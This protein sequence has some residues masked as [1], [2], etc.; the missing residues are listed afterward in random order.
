M[1]LLQALVRCSI[2]A[3]FLSLCLQL[4]TG[5]DDDY[6]NRKPLIVQMSPIQRAKADEVSE[7]RC[8]VSTQLRECMPIKFYILTSTKADCS[9]FNEYE[10]CIC[11]GD[12][13]R[14]F[15]WNIRCKSSINV[16]CVA[17]AT[18][19]ANVCDPYISVKVLNDRRSYKIREFVVI[20]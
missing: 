20:S 14:N 19:D 6:D 10:A 13:P 9:P 1:P 11:P 8:N 17:D 4:V 2:T 5:Q 3:L 16:A 12:N 15:Y 7:I 18:E